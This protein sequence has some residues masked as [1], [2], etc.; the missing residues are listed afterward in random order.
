ME[1]P[2]PLIAIIGPTACGKTALSIRL[3]QR[4]GGTV[5]SADSRQVY[6]GMKLGTGKVTKREMNGVPHELLDVADPKRQFTVVDFQRR[7]ARVMRTAKTPFW[8]VGGS[9]LYVDA[10]VY[11]QH[12]PIVKPNATLRKKLEGWSTPRLIRELQKLDPMRAQTIDQKNRRRLIRALEIVKSTGRPIPQLERRDTNA[13]ILGINL[14]RNLLY[15]RINVRLDARL[16]LGMITEVR[17]LHEA[18]VSWKRLESFGLEYRFIARFLQ[19]QITKSEMISQLQGAIHAFARRQMTWWKR[20]P[21]IRW[22][23]NEAE[24]ARWIRSYLQE[25]AAKA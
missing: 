7:V 18:G 22:I 21:N 13:L 23:K 12:F 19:G 6:R 16:R 4:F 17:R 9:P 25:M 24:A 15:R 1:L 11:E 10:I 20:D 3:A 14:P 5:I 8:L 2:K